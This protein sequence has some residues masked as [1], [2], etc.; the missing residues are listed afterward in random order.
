MMG[1]DDTKLNS[2]I[3]VDDVPTSIPD[4]EIDDPRLVATLAERAAR[5]QKRHRTSQATVEHNLDPDAV[6]KP[7]CF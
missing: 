4:Q 7:G 3:N 2:R 5:R 1:Q 6:K